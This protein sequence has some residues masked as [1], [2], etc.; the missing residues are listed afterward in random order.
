MTIRTSIDLI[1][2]QET[3]YEQCELSF[4]NFLHA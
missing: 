1:N 4:E 2:A 3:P